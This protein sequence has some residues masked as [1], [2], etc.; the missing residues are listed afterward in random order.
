MDEQRYL[1]VADQFQEALLW[2]ITPDAV[3]GLTVAGRLLKEIDTG[4]GCLQL[5]ASLQKS[6]CHSAIVF[7]VTLVG[8]NAEDLEGRRAVL[9]NARSEE[10]T[11]E[12]QSRQ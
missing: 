3:M 6:D 5:Q 1:G 9:V 8:G 10:H 2:T 12:L 4:N 11:S 7:A